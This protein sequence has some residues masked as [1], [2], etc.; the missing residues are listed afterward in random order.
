MTLNEQLEQTILRRRLRYIQKKD[1][2]FSKRLQREYED[3]SDINSTVNT[4]LTLVEPFNTTK[5]YQPN[6]ITN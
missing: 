3:V 1:R 4:L 2:L 6:E 5:E